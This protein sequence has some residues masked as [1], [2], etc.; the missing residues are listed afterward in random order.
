MADDFGFAPPAF[1]P[2]DALHT[3]RLAL[4]ALGLVER[5]G[6]FERR[7]TPIPRAAVDGAVLRAARVKRPSRN[8]PEWLD[9][10]L[11]SKKP[12]IAIHDVPLEWCFQPGV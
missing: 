6:R 5:A 1:Q 12:A 3:L 11:G 8:S 9:K 4:R 10:A 2:E 7:G